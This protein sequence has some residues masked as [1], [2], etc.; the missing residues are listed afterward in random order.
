MLSLTLFLFF[1]AKV[2]TAKPVD[3]G[4]S[5]LLALKPLLPSAPLLRRLKPLI[6]SLHPSNENDQM[7]ETNM[8]ELHLIFDELTEG[9][10]RPR[11]MGLIQS[12]LR[13]ANSALKIGSTDKQEVVDV[14]KADAAATKAFVEA[15]KESG[16]Y[17]PNLDDTA[18][19][20][21]DEF[22][23]QLEDE[24][25]SHNFQH[26]ETPP[27]PHHPPNDYEEKY[28]YSEQEVDEEA[29]DAG[30]LSFPRIR[31]ELPADTV[32]SS[33]DEED[34][35]PD[36]ELQ[37]KL[38][39]WRE[40]ALIRRYF[41]ILEDIA[42][43]INSTVGIND[44]TAKIQAV[45][46]PEVRD[47]LVAATPDIGNNDLWEAVAQA[48][49]NY[50][51]VSEE[52]KENSVAAE[53]LEPVRAGVDIYNQYADWRYDAPWEVYDAKIHARDQILQPVQDSRAQWIEK[54]DEL[55]EA[56]N[57]QSR[58]F[59]NPHVTTAQA[60]RVQLQQARDATNAV[61]ND[62]ILHE[63]GT[64]LMAIRT[65]RDIAYILKEAGTRA[66]AICLLNPACCGQTSMCPPFSIEQVF[67]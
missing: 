46:P 7:I 53:Y 66:T 28:V 45:I 36:D 18:R 63:Y 5:V 67:R 11:S 61:V 10:A 22:A 39:Y 4:Q 32:V 37:A 43:P 47:A 25:V 62:T 58:A 23:Q 13:Q 64:A 38:D 41:A 24:I 27:T 9:S 31:P 55:L 20:L 54:R 14:H 8:A 65:Q 40:Q 60:T 48:W 12:V 19:E 29:D 34:G 51:D 50:L 21:E 33:L 15:L 52:V 35:T 1:L 57:E 42:P 44:V 26:D 59:W 30:L 17:I 16:V 6:S 3:D 2:S 56:K 49:Q